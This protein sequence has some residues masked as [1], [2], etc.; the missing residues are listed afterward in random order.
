[1]DA[2]ELLA[3]SSLSDDHADPV[4]D[5]K[6]IGTDKAVRSELLCFLSDKCNVMPLD[7]L[8]K[9]CS[10]FYRVEEVVFARSMINKFGYRLPKRKGQDKVKNTVED[11]AK[12]ILHPEH[13]LPTFYA[14]DLSRLPPVDISHCDVSAILI[15]LR[16]LRSEVRSTKQL[17]DDLGALREQVAPLVSQ[18]ATQSTEIC[19]L[20]SH[21]ADM[22]SLQTTVPSTDVQIPLSDIT[23]F[24]QLNSAASGGTVTQLQVQPQSHVASGSSSFVGKAHELIGDPLAFA[25]TKPARKLVVGASLANKHVKAV[26]TSRMVNIFVSRLHPETKAAELVDS[27]HS[28]KGDLNVQDVVCEKLNSKFESLYCSYHV[29]IRVDSVD[30]KQA[31]DTFMSASSWPSG[32]FVKRF[33]LKKSNGTA[34]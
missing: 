22:C 9:V 12:T 30:L 17:Q 16:A 18:A 15:E 25:G 10:D 8:V 5:N 27:V 13:A 2:S 1:M 3:Q 34:E 11:L 33:F 19:E 4:S 24:P 7:D 21:M 20:R 31:I 14:T 26:A 6:E 28:V 23:E 29:A 32:V